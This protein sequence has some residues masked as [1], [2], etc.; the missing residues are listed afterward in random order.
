MTFYCLVRQF[1]L[2]AWHELVAAHCN[3]QQPLCVPFIQSH[4]FISN[5][6]MHAVVRD[7][8]ALR[9]CY[10]DDDPNFIHVN[11]EEILR[12]VGELESELG[13]ISTYFTASSLASLPSDTMLTIQN[14]AATHEKLQHLVIRK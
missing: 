1:Q 13:G 11:V 2:G 3:T 9:L 8:V 5:S 10:V 4:F 12:L 14:Y 7:L 6:I